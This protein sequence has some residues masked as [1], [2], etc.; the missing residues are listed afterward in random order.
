MSCLELALVTCWPIDNANRRTL[1]IVAMFACDHVANGSSYPNRAGRTRRGLQPGH[2]VSAPS[3]GYRVDAVLP[4]LE[5]PKWA[6]TRTVKPMPDP[7]HVFQTR[8]HYVSTVESARG[9]MSGSTPVLA[10]AIYL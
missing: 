10:M 8:G 4:G 6:F 2:G 9:L 3:R 5:H 1:N 7:G